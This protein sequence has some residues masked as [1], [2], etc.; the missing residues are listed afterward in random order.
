MMVGHGLVT[1]LV[2]FFYFGLTALV[3]FLDHRRRTNESKRTGRIDFS[4]PDIMLYLL[5]GLLLGPLPLIV[6][7]FRPVSPIPR[8]LG[9]R[10][11]PRRWRAAGDD[12]RPLR[13]GRLASFVV[14]TVARQE[15]G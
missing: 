8:R 14:L 3:I 12:G 4:S 1:I 11:R 7:L 2:W 6:Y 10:R 15:A 13:H 5:L 9:A